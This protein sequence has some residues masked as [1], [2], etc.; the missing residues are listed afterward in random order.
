[1]A[2]IL[3]G[4]NLLIPIKKLGISIKISIL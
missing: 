4:A 2:F 1:M 3:T